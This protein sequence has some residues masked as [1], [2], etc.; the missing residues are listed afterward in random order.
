M[1]ATEHFVN[2]LKAVAPQLPGGDAAWL[3]EA[4]ADAL[5]RFASMGLPT[6]RNEDW[7][8]TSVRPIEKKAFS[9]SLKAGSAVSAQDVEAYLFAGLPVHLLTFVDG[10]Y[11]A[12]LSRPGD[13]ADGATV[14]SLASALA[15]QPDALRGRLASLADPAANGF[16]ALNTASMADGAY[17]HVSRNVKLDRPVHLLFLATRQDAEVFAQPRNLIVMEEGAEAVVIES[18]GSIG[19]SASLTNALTE[20]LLEA[21]AGL[22]HYTLQVESAQAYHIAT[23]QAK[24][25]AGSRFVSH[26]VSF[27]ARIARND[28]N[29]VLDAEGAHCGLNGLYMVD[30][31][32]HVDYH[33]R[34]D[35]AQPHCSSDEYY[36]GILDGHGRGV[37]NGRVY[38]HPHAQKTDAQ[39]A[40]KNLLLSR[41]AEIDT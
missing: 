6:Q 35:H 28:I 19:D 2:A 11:S 20:V 10:H 37:F 36:K 25:A 4:R 8:Y 38:V 9:P 33:T 27:G 7:K 18:Y 29:V 21:N 15:S 26:S 16:A 31:R 13:L 32:Q 40:N 14:S 5:S 12:A 34:I 30:G 41:D 1:S 39:Q 24:Q 17:I 22:E 23:L 3:S